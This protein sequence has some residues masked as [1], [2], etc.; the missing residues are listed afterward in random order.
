MPLDDYLNQIIHG[1]S[2]EILPSLPEASIDLIFADP[3]YN[4]QL[5]KELWR[6]DLTH[7]DAVD[8]E[9]DQFE[10]FEA[11]D[12]FTIAWLTEAR[13][14]MKDTAT[15]WVSGTYH[16]IFRVGAIMQNLGFW[17][18]NT[19]S[20]FKPNAMP[21]FNGTRFKNDIEFVI[22]AQRSEKSS[23][24]FHHHLMKQ[25]NDFNKGKQLG[26][27]WKIPV[28]GGGERLKDKNGNKLHSTQKPEELLRRIILAS[29][30][31]GEMVLDPFAGTGTT[32]AM[33]KKLRREWI[34]I[35][36]NE[37]YISYA[38]E[39]VSKV[40]PLRKNH[41]LITETTKPKPKRVSFKSL[42]EYDYIEVGQSL[43]F[44]DP[45]LT[46]TILENGRLKVNGHEG[47]IHQLGQQLK[48]APTCNGWMH[49][50]Y[51][52]ENNERQPIDELR[53][54]FRRADRKS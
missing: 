47:S 39:R 4:L 17:I 5:S 48:K 9:W 49:W 21:N 15:I 54:A 42:L 22:W 37:I 12:E 27:V 19:I 36:R 16:N 40:K 34:G 41:S 11:Y 28:C 38:Q 51:V 45:E 31:P 8:D 14:V 52:D 24:T 20:W 6:P 23:K 35:E 3:P 18:L 30:K 46:A 10:S 29:S 33:A 50:F 1:D 13:R 44:D 43:Y 25:F 32:P 2:L 53:K 7:V 26:S